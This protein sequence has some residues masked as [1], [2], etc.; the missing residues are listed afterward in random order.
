MPDQRTKTTPALRA[1]I[2]ETKRASGCNN[3]EVARMLNVKP[4]VVGKVLRAAGVGRFT[5][6]RD[7]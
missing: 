4:G 2:I 6:M 3:R 1:R 5:E 7:A